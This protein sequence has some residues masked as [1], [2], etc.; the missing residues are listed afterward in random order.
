MP[1]QIPVTQ[2]G[3]EAS[4][5]QAM[6]NAGRNTQINLGTNSRQINALAQPLGRITGQADEFTKS[7]EAA[8]AR[9][10]AFGASVGIINGVSKAFGAL[11]RNTIEVEKSLVEI[12]TVLNRSGDALQDFGNKLFDVAKTTGQTFD[13]VAK[14]ALELARQGLNTEDTLKRINDALILSR[15]SGLDAQQSVEGLTAAFNS[16]KETGITTSQIL[17][18]LVVVSQQYSVSERDLIEGLKRSASVADQAGVSF[19]ELVGI[20]TTVQERTARG[21]AVI[22]NAFKTI[23][24]RIQDTGALQDLSNLGIKVD[25]LEGKILPATKILQNLGAE[26]NNLSQLEQ[27]DIA[28]KLGGVYQL[29]NLLAAVKDLS[30]EQSKYNDI[31]KLSAGATNEAYQKNAALNE[32]LASLINKVNLSA[33]QLGATLGAI[34]ITDSLKGLLSFFNNVLEDIQKILGEESALGTFVQGLAKGIGSVLAGPGLALF[35]AIIAKLSKDLI[36]FGVESLKSFFKIGQSAKEIA[37]VEKAIAAAL[38]S[39]LTLQRQLF[40]LEGN[41]AA[42]LKLMTDAIVQQEAVMRR[43]SATAGSLAG[44]L[45]QQGV[46]STGGQGLRV[47]Q[48]AGGYMPAVSQESRDINR[49]VGG[50]KA[51]D[52]PVVIP[53][54][55]FGGGKKGTMV[56]HTGEYI[57][58]NFA[59]GGSAIFNR[60]MVRSMGLPA[61]AKKIGAAGGFIPNFAKLKELPQQGYRDFNWGS[62][63]EA[64]KAA[65]DGFVTYNNAQYRIS[66]SQF[67]RALVVTDKQKKV[68]DVASIL[69]DDLPTILTPNQSGLSAIYTKKNIFG[70]GKNA[71]FKFE[72]FGLQANGKQSIRNDFERKF[73]E[74]TIKNLANKT[75]LSYAR[76][77]VSSLDSKNP[78]EPETLEEV[79]KVKGFIGSVMGAFGGIFD[80]AVTTGIRAASIDNDKNIENIGGD[81]DVNARGDARD[82]IIKLFGPNSIPNNGLAD[83]KINKGKYAVK[84]MSEKILNSPLFA[85][86]L[87]KSIGVAEAINK[88]TIKASR[89]YIPNFAKYIYDSDRIAP[90]KGATLKA[91]LASQIKKNLI[92]GPAGS[93]KSTLA[94]KMGKFLSGV[95]DVANA[96]EI[97]I[98]SGAARAKGGGISKNL[99]AIISAVNNSGGKVSY[100]YAKNLDI[101]SRRAGRTV[102]EE[103]DLRSKKQLKGTTYAPLNQFDFMG[104]VKSKSRNFNLVNGAKGFIPNFADPLKEAIDREMSAGVPA[105][106]IYVD[107]NSS[108]K[109]SMNPMGLMVANR[110]DEP[111]GGMQGISRARKEGANPMLYG[112]AGGFVPNFQRRVGTG[113]IPPQSLGGQGSSSN[114]LE[115]PKRDLLGVI[116]AIQTGLTFLNGATSDATSGLGKFTNAIGSIASSASTALL[117][118]QGLSGLAKEG[119]RAAGILGR[120][121]V[122][123]AVLAGGFELYKQLFIQ[124]TKEGG[125]AIAKFSDAVNQA[126]VS[127]D[128]LSKSAQQQSLQGAEGYLKR[129]GFGASTGDDIVGRVY[130]DPETQKMFAN[131]FRISGISEKDLTEKL[132]AGGALQKRELTGENGKSIPVF[133]QGEKMGTA[134]EYYGEDLDKTR[135]VLSE[136]T[137][138]PEKM[139]DG[140][141]NPEYEKRI[142]RI[143]ELKGEQA[144][145]EKDINEP[146]ENAIRLNTA[147]ISLL[148]QQL[149]NRIA[150]KNALFEASGA[151][152]YS[153]ELQKE[154]LSVGEKERTAAGYKLQALQDAKKLTL[155]QEKAT[156][157]VLK[158][159]ELINKKLEGAGLGGAIDETKFKEIAGISEEISDLIKQQGG[160]TQEVENK[161]QSLLAPIVKNKEQQDL[162]LSLLKESNSEV[163]KRLTLESKLNALSNLQKATIEAANFATEKRSAAITN[164]YD[165]QLKLNEL[166]KTDLD[167]A[168]EKFKVGKERQKI[169]GEA[170]GNLSVDRQIFEQEKL[171]I[172]A[173]LKIDQE[174]LLIQVR[175]TLS[176]AAMQVGY[177][178]EELSPI[179]KATSQK[180]FETIVT[181]IEDAEK[182]AQKTKI[183]QALDEVKLKNN[184][185]IL[186]ATTV[187]TSANYFLQTVKTA[188][189]YFRNNPLVRFLGGAAEGAEGAPISSE[190]QKANQDFEAAQ[191]SLRS[192][193]DTAIKLAEDGMRAVDALPK[194]FSGLFDV[195]PNAM[196]ESGQAAEEAG[197]SIGNLENAL[198]SAGGSLTTFANLVRG[199]FTSLPETIAQNKF[200]MLTATDTQSIIGNAVEA[201]RN[202][203]LSQGP[204]SAGT[205]AQAA[206]ATAIYEKELEIKRAIT[207]EDKINGEFELQKL[208]EIL[209]LRMQLLEAE[210]NEEREAIIDRIIAKE[211]QRLPVLQRIKA[212]F[213]STTEQRTAELEDSLVNASVQFRDNLIDGI[214]Q[215]IEGGG[216]LKDILLNTALE[217]TREITKASLKNAI[218]SIGN[219][220]NFGGGGGVTTAA[221]GGMITGGSGTKDDVPAM[222]MGGEYVVNKK[223]VQKYGPEF[224]SAINNGTLGG[225]AKGGSVKKPTQTGEGG[226]F[227]PGLY[228]NE[229]ISGTDALMS[230]ATQ[231]YTSGARDVISSGSNFASIDL[232]QE[233]V[234]LTQR[235]REN[236]PL[237]AATQSAKEQ[238]LGMVFEQVRREEEYRKAIEEAKKQE[239]AR[240]KAIR[241][242]LLI[243]SAMAIGSA[244]AGP[245]LGAAG[246]GAK[247]AF[248][249][250][251]AAGGTLFTNIGAAAKGVF[252]G[253]QVGGQMVGGLGNL[254]TGVGKTLTGNF[255]E[256]GNFFKLSQIGDA[257]GLAK[258][259]NAGLGLDGKTSN[260]TKFLDKSGYVPRA[261]VDEVGTN[262]VGGNWFSRL[263]GG[264]RN[265]FGTGSNKDS[266]GFESTAQDIQPSLWER[267][268][269]KRNTIDPYSLISEDEMAELRKDPVLGYGVQDPRSWKRRATGGTIPETSG[270]DTIPTMLSGGEF[271]MNRAASQNI[272]AGNLQ[273]LNAGASA[274]PT[275]EKTEELNDKLISKLDE[276]IQANSS[277][278]SVG[279]ININVDGSGKSNESS[280]AGQSGTA[281]QQLARNIRDMVVKVIQDEQRLGGLLR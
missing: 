20:I 200:A 190:Q 173:K 277:K 1:L 258:A 10:F 228:G 7:M 116:F 246:A 93:G 138:M 165:Q 192:S 35:G 139:V 203:I 211:K 127:I 251:K 15:L 59:G 223:S 204:A 269:G 281:N 91:V 111:A 14:G 110:R 155:E 176:E 157:D 197:I 11:V 70:S 189:D 213:S 132:V 168:L 119:S 218:G 260:F 23:F 188:A 167:I 243:S 130:K 104:Y 225:Y 36:G 120:L 33:Q 80:A 175:K 58:P 114:N 34:G 245:L 57:I 101:L 272:G 237:F 54:F 217:F 146:T 31:V 266:Q 150:Y 12:N 78:I 64:S 276:L 22:G 220:F 74:D 38:G 56:A 27:A 61:G 271:I 145:I 90:D 238:A 112:A 191:A 72:S 109:N 88:A 86:K 17:N 68:I 135:K 149:E 268:T 69:G 98:L 264:F 242:Q 208:K 122:A 9:V 136:I 32:T 265:P 206:D 106:Q 182:Q 278:S 215:A 76:K 164:E 103:G 71:E 259:Y 144:Q 244:V 181:A 248:G 95:G 67:D 42:Q 201:R 50:A 194:N 133:G 199:V 161:A 66:K 226:Y 13:T 24:A 219:L 113:A 83:F 46:R 3:L 227:L 212:E 152:E 184:S 158:N 229:S 92:I 41:R 183:Q 81:F 231:N 235:G 166:R 247:A 233:S 53:N 40:A 159:S 62:F 221:T 37:S 84:S 254:F 170:G 275:E 134:Y 267:I 270:I 193:T 202:D 51:G 137:A 151:E 147:N 129:M 77:I 186:Q 26:F 239:K 187:Q 18:K 185:A 79:D 279:A 257:Q 205:I 121:G 273:A 154:M 107:Q 75:A 126:G 177:K 234:R 153:L 49:G 21:G 174:D 102:A 29:S 48:A 236:S 209:P 108:L 140:K 25:D 222:L 230:F 47:P 163:E 96:S 241:K 210:T 28:K 6:R 16:F 232:E 280:S 207:A 262:G 125:Q 8:N 52:K 55:A 169:G 179:S 128:N 43:M 142:K 224:L 4:I 252:T 97:D 115:G 89:G 82:N 65:K 256:A 148:K 94:G 39:N 45:Y 240:Q 162:I 63:E 19:D 60:D 196:R 171:T 118:G 214:S 44:S 250:S 172:N 5:Q 160:Y 255:A 117:V 195:Y 198:L 253:G 100:L 131:A 143:L 141:I 263:I 178:P 216:S 87:S 274:L 105:S 123:G 99:E 124:P 2:T 249:A 85:N 180:E 30:S 156:I 261:I 73:N